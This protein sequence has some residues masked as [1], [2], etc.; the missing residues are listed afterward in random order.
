MKF[1]ILVILIFLPSYLVSAA[2]NISA[3]GTIS[4]SGY[5]VLNQ[6]VTAAGRCFL[7]SIGDVSLD[8]Q[9]YNITY[10]TGGGNG[11]IGIDAASATVTDNLTIKNCFIADY[12]TGGTTGYGIRLTRFSNSTISN[13]SIYTSGSSSN[14]GIYLITSSQNN[15]IKNNTIFATGTTTGNDGI[16]IL[17]TAALACNYNN[18]LG[19]VIQTLGTTTNYGVFLSTNV[20]FTNVSNNIII[21]NGT[22]TNHGIYLSGGALTNPSNNNY[23]FN[24][25][26]QTY[27]TTVG[28]TGGYGIYLQNSA[29]HNM[30]LSN[31]INTHGSTA[32]YGVYLVGTAALPSSYNIVDSNNILT[33]GTTTNN[34]G[35][36]L[37]TNADYNNVT[38]NVINTSGST[39]NDG[40]V[41]LG[42]AAAASTYNFI[43]DN[44]IRTNGT[45]ATNY[46]VYL[47]TNSSFNNVSGNDI[48][49]NGTNTNYGIYLSGAALT[50]PANNNYIFNNL[51]RTY[52]TAG[53]NNFGIYFQNSVSSNIVLGNNITTYGTTTNYGIYFIGAAA[54]SPSY[55]L[56][57]SNVILAQGTATNN[58][59]VYLLTNADYTNVT[60]NI[61][62]TSG[63]TGNDGIVISGTNAASTYNFIFDNTIRTHGTGAN[64]H[65]IY[66]F[67]NS[68]FNNVSGN[69]II[70][71]GTATS[72]GIYLWGSAVATPVNNNEVSYNS[73][74]TKCS[75]ASSTCHGIYLQNLATN[76]SILGNSITTGV[77]SDNYGI[78]LFGT[79]ALPLNFTT[80]DSNTLNVS[81]AD[82]INIAA[83]VSNVT[84]HNNSIIDKDYTHYDINISAAGVNGT[85][86]IDQYFENYTFTGVGESITVE[87]SNYGKIVFLNPINGSGQ[88]F[89]KDISIF[90]NYIYVNSSQ[91]GLNK[92]A[93]LTLYDLTFVNPRILRDGVA[94]VDCTIL[95]YTFGNL[96]F[97]VTHF[98]N[99]S[100][101]ET[102]N[103]S[104]IESMSIN[105][106]IF[107][108]NEIILSAGKTQT[109]NC[110]AIVTDALG[111]NNIIGANATFYYYKNSSS[112]ND[113][114]LVHYTD[115]SCDL[116]QINS[117]HDFFS[118]S[119]DVWYYANNGTWNC[120]ITVHNNQ[121]VSVYNMTNTS[122]DPLYAVNITD[123]IFFSNVSSNIP[124]NNVT[125]NITNFG[126][127]PVNIT[128]QGY[129][130]VIGD[131]TGMNCSDSTNIN[132]TNIRFSTNTALDFNQ[133]TQMTG[134][135]QNLNFQIAKQTN[136]TP[137]FN[138]TYWQISPDPGTAYRICTGY[139]IFNAEAP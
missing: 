61:I 11:L 74:Q 6:S 35:I 103:P 92:S 87:N 26:I 69:D 56:I 123:G 132:I 136:I 49:T 28:T 27:G 48:I 70:A 107:P 9:G 85:S 134:S 2:T 129:A 19:N 139:I 111:A 101:D 13:N 16:Y 46:G 98:S 23:I 43:F 58:Y 81:K 83:G 31:N 60:N 125:V 112:D 104:I 96:L 42:T 78:Y 128:I 109:V 110:T 94:C 89:S 113:N 88:N 67:T 45:G 32:N 86:F 30:I 77:T 64:N 82:S 12:N 121:S 65:G 24:N 62:N 8:C 7:I 122:I 72:Y 97:N 52:G 18:V 116:T 137:I 133:K 4:S 76:S 39:G 59:G 55:N 105:D 99:Y 127:M 126:N 1:I 119:F 66:V 130:L 57:D 38:N 120:N 25:S 118:C 91:K 131:N 37:S 17:G 21:T 73:V 15:T 53:A 106:S 40:I 36:Y 71:N 47:L 34:Y 93:K 33:Q 80:I 135:I 90:Y 51:V 50:T 3:C 75:T 117:T 14:Y 79:A 138:T 54:L 124:S 10:A 115:T 68:N 41:V 102:P 20:S 84:L 5:Y 95:N 29:V 114:T 44:T 108:E 100:V 22:N 63:S